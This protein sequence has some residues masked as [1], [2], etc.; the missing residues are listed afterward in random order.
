MNVLKRGQRQSSYVLRGALFVITIEL[1][2]TVERVP[3][4]GGTLHAP[5]GPHAH[6]GRP[7]DSSVI[8]E[9]R[10]VQACKR[11]VMEQTTAGPRFRLSTI[12]TQRRALEKSAMQGIVSRDA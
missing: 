3:V 9:G 8:P 12:E 1:R 7:L 11:S 6:H 2:C 10:P 5:H 4:E